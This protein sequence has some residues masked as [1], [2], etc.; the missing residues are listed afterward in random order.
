MPFSL[1]SAESQNIPWAREGGAKERVHSL[2][3]QIGL[4]V[5]SWTSNDTISPSS[6]APSRG[7]VLP[8]SNHI[9]GFLW[10]S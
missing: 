3:D 7:R 4:E 9:L 5:Q 6:S 1:L 2:G 10:T 8:L